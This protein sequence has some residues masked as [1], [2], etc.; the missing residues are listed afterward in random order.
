MDESLSHVCGR[1]EQSAAACAE[2]QGDSIVDLHT[3][4]LY[5]AVRLASGNIFW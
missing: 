1:L 2:F 4:V 5:T 3:C